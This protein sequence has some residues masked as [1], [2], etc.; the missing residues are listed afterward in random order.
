[1]KRLLVG[2]C[3]LGVGVASA[4][5]AD[6]ISVGE[7]DGVITISKKGANFSPYQTYAIADY[8]VDLCIQPESGTPT[9]ESLAQGGAGGQTATTCAPTSHSLD[10]AVVESLIEQLDSLGW[11]QVAWKEKETADL[12]VL[13]SWQQKTGWALELPYCYPPNYVS[14]CVEPLTN[15]RL[16]LRRL[17]DTTIVPPLL[18]Q[19][20]DTAESSS[21]QLANIWTA[22]IDQQFTIGE[23]LGTAQGGANANAI[24]ALRTAITKAFEQSPQLSGNN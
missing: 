11:T 7:T 16:T 10:A 6:P 5:A 4:C 23:T 13:T 8:V 19:L 17:E 3:L 9:S 12:L 14:G 18:I 20:V 21:T 15:S 22:A 2:L 1:M 24:G